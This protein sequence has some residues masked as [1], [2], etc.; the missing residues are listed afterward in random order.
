MIGIRSA[1]RLPSRTVASAVALAIT[2]ILIPTFSLA[3][4]WPERIVRITTPSAPVAPST[5]RLGC[6]RSG[7]RNAGGSQS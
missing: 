6:S 2:A 3:G 5:L 4:S 7:W 1:H